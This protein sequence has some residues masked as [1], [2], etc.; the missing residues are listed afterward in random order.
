LGLGIESNN[1]AEAMALW[2]GLIQEKKHRIQNLII[3]GDSIVIIQA[4]IHHSKTQNATLNNLLD[5]IQLLLRRFNSYKLHHVLREQNGEADEEANRG[6]LLELGGT[7][8][9]RNGTQ[10]GSPLKYDLPS[11]SYSNA[12]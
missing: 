5:K 9:E 4:M 2:Q 10:H 11:I 6:T 3:I 12:S 8:C 7:E 1:R